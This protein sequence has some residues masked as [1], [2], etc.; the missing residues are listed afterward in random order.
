VL[1]S[2]P[3]I[4]AFTAS[5]PSVDQGAAS[6]LSWD[7]TDAVSASVDPDVGAVDVDGSAT[8][9]PGATTTYTLTAV[10]AEGIPSTATVTVTV[11]A[12]PSLTLVEPVA[13]DVWYVG[14][15]RHVRY[16]GYRVEEVLGFYT[17]D[18]S[19]W[20][21]L[22]HA[23]VNQVGW[24]DHAWTVP[25]EPT[26]ACTIRVQ[27]YMAT[28]AAEETIEIRRI[29]DGDGDGMD[30][31]WETVTFG[32]LTHDA[33][34]DEDGDGIT[35]YDEFMAGSDPLVAA[36]GGYAGG[37]VLSCAAG[38]ARE[39]AAALSILLLACCLVVATG[40]AREKTTDG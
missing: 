23:Y 36:P 21:D 28:L 31:D 4:V 8:V 37:G 39:G 9:T 24:Q 19:T 29:D 13:G 6:L 7:T 18:G 35:D 25:D 1:P 38:E 16:A 12:P 5:P 3:D 15:T 26:A 10:N 22:F 33:T 34:S 14:T 20:H 32:D 27:D 17:T 2:G 30:D 11:Q 40:G